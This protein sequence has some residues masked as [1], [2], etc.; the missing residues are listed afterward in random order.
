[1]GAR[2]THPAGTPSAL[3]RARIKAT[4]KVVSQ[5]NDTDAL[6]CPKC[7]AE[8]RERKNRRDGTVFYGCARYPECRY[9]RSR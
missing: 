2:A 9:T 3:E 5:K 1:M 4:A 6:R 7:G 8:L